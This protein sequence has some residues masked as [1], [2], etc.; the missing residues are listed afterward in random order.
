LRRYAIYYAPPDAA[1]LS[2]L[3][4]AWLGR[5]A[6]T[7]AA[8]PQPLVEGIVPD[9]LAAITAS[10][11]LYGFHATL[12]PPFALADGT[13]AAGL[14]EAVAALAAGLRRFELPIVLGEIEGFLALVPAVPTPSI[15][16]LAAACVAGLDRWRRPAE[17]AELARRR[18]GGLAP[19]AEANLARWGYPWVMELFRFHMTLT[20]RLAEPE[21]HRVRDRLGLLVAPHVV[22]PLVIDGLAV[23][24]QPAPGAPFTITSRHPF[25]G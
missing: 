7:G 20:D 16:A 12:K 11:R 22:H 10:P 14:H 5:D 6:A 13:D 25:G 24:E 19:E 3:A 2:R 4:A 9:R 17:P 18:A 23:F 15:D 1:P 8:V 21:R